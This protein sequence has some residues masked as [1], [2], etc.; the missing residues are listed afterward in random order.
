MKSR[1]RHL[2]D[3]PLTRVGGRVD[4]ILG[5]DN[6][7]LIRGRKI[8]AGDTDGEPVA[9]LSKL[10][11][12]VRGPTGEPDTDKVSG[13]NVVVSHPGGNVS[14]IHANGVLWCG[15]ESRARLL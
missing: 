14:S 15:I 8:R 5:L 13:V 9:T 2:A 4:M 6:Y 7:D 12:F 3:L 11:W 10:G 1:W